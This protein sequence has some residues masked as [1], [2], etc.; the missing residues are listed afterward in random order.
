MQSI[1]TFF[2]YIVANQLIIKLDPTRLSKICLDLQTQ[3]QAD[4]YSPPTMTLTGSVTSTV[5]CCSH[6]LSSLL[7]LRLLSSKSLALL[8]L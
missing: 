4:A 6:Q 2:Y 1:V 5:I 8:A 3:T 7:R